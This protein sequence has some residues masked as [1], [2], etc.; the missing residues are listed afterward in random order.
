M[1]KQG[2]RVI[3]GLSSLA[4]LVGLAG[5][6][7]K[8]KSSTPPAGT[9]KAPSS[10]PTLRVTDVN[11]GK[12]VAADKSIADRSDSFGATDTFYVSVKTEGASPSASLT[13]R[14]TYEDGQV[15]EESTQNIASNGSV[16]YTEFHVSKPD[17][18]PPGAYKVTVLLNGA[19]AGHRD[20]RVS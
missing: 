5:C 11:V 14:W 2:R 6:S 1:S 7:P 8:P 13:A 9:T 17:G 20:F 18:W 12:S 10:Q 19:P 16:S 4:L 3:V 15:V